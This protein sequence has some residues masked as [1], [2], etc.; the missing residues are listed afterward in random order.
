MPT[1]QSFKEL[2]RSTRVPLEIS[3]EVE[4][5]PG[6][7][8]GATVVVNLHGALIRTAKPL[9]PG[10]RIRVT[11]YVTSK[12]AAAKVVYVAAHRPLECGIELELAQNIWGVSLPP[13]DWE[14]EG[15]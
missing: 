15:R 13:N 4:G 11:V 8:K 10:S 3:V 1:T 12:A 6:E 7:V 9:Q 2:R 5:E 14:E